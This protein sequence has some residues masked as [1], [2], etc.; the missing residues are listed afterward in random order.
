M[1]NVL[2]DISKIKQTTGPIPTTIE[3]DNNVIENHQEIANLMTSKI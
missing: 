3:S 1:W 2:R